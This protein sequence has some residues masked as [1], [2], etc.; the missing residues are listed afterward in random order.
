MAKRAL[1]VDDSK[2][3]R[4]VL[5]SKLQK[6]GI[7][8]ETRESAAAAIDYL[9]DN[10][11]DAIFMDFEM[12]GMDGF[13][14]LKVIKSNPN[15]AIIPVMMY[16]S[17]SGGLEIS[18]ARALC[19][20]GVLPKELEPQDL[21][22]VLQSLHLMPEQDSLVHD[23]RD[24]EYLATG[25]VRAGENVLSINDGDRRRN[26][27]V[28]PISLP[29]D[30]LGESLFDV[31]GLKRFIRRE[32]NQTEHRLQD[33]LDKHFSELH[34]ELYELQGEEEI[35]ARQLRRSVLFSVLGLLLIGA[36][37]VGFALYMS[38]RGVVDGADPIKKQVDA[39][40]AMI[41]AQDEKIDQMSQQMGSAT[42]ASEGQTEERPLPIG[43]IEWAASQG[44]RFG[45]GETPFDDKRALWLAALE[46]KLR[47]A[48]FRGTIELRANYGNFCLS[49]DE[50]G[51]LIMADPN[52]DIG[53]CIFAAEQ[54]ISDL[55]QNEQTVTFA[56]YLNV[57][58]ARSGGDIEILLFSSGFSDPIVPYP[59][60]YDVK[61][62]GEWNR[63]AS[64]NQRIQ[65]SLYSNQ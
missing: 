18:Q 63:I 3:A 37:V 27:V 7:A 59:G 4:Q 50:T 58:A 31:D 1:I 53:Q 24:D 20:V 42:A 48:G 9:Y 35:H 6:Y 57:D 10:A 61:N 47:E 23:F 51:A 11:P 17:R 13:Q 12:P 25:R 54:K 44:N 28:E 46:E 29:L 16:T 38:G 22:G 36:A 43:L 49:K 65:V 40:Q 33:R 60:R 32:Q 56:N 15:T 21:E 19:A 2:T 39:L 45:F 41:V 8:V 26:R 30:S 52:L 64:Q 62:A 55:Q 34:S 5:S 14:A